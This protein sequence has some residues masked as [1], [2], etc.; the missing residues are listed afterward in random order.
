MPEGA[1]SAMS[2][3]DTYLPIILQWGV[4][5]GGVLLA[6]W[7]ATRIANW[8]QSQ[9]VKH[10]TSTGFD[11]T[12]ARFAGSVARYTLLVLAVLSCLEVFGIQTTSFAALIGAA[13]LAIGLAFQGTLSNVSGGVMIAALRPFKVGDCISAGGETGVVEEISLMTTELNLP[14]GTRIHVPNGQ[15][16]SGVIQNKSHHGYMQA[17]VNVGVDYSADLDRTRAVLQAAADSVPN[18][19]ADPAPVV[20]CTGLGASSVDWQVRVRCTV[21]NYWGVLEAATVLTKK[22]LDEAGIGIPYKT[23]DVNVI[24]GDAADLEG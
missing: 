15:V 9:I 6:L 23:I 16:I 20:V 10:L 22:A 4:R 12:L 17:E 5:I 19:V 1:Q 2:K 11:H 14:N 8:L 7:V 21:A 3:L 24:K 18:A 13:G